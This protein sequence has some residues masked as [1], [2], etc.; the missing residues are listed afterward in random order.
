MSHATCVFVDPVT[1]LTYPLSAIAT[2][3]ASG[4]WVP[5]SCGEEKSNFAGQSRVEGSKAHGEEW[6]EV[7]ASTL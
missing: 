5:S 2:E 1:T 4:I 6:H 3:R 7:I